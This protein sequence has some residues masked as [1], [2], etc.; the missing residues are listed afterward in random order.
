MIAMRLKLRLPDETADAIVAASA[1]KVDPNAAFSMLQP[2][3]TVPSVHSTA[4][5]TLNRE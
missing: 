4:A 1:H 3:N 2:V 5:P